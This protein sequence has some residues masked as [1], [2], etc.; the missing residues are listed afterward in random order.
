MQKRSFLTEQQIEVLKLRELGL[1]QK[2]I[3]EKIGTTRENVSIIEKRGR[4]NIE[5]SRETLKEWRRIKAPIIIKI[6]KGTD[7]LN[8]PKQIFDE[9]DRKGIKVKSNLIEILTRLG[10]DK[11][12]LIKNRILIGDLEVLIMN[13]GEVRLY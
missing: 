10:M 7:I 1:T 2:E 4:T 12:G 3:S 8:I 11:R 5:R 13:D 6:D 9:A